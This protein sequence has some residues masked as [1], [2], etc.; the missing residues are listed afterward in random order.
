[1]G[2]IEEYWKIMKRILVSKT[3]ASISWI[4]IYKSS[5]NSD[6]SS[7]FV[8]LPFA[9]NSLGNVPHPSNNIVGVINF[10]ISILFSLFNDFYFIF[11]GILNV[12]F[13]IRFKACHSI[14]KNQQIF[15]FKFIFLH[16]L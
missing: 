16:F 15:R 7:Q 10:H 14:K 5:P 1:M 8:Q 12:T 3:H 2:R 4:Y 11:L 13:T 9:Q 6:S